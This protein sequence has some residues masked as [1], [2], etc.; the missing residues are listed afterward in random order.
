VVALINS[1]R[2]ILVEL[3]ERNA[4]KHDLAIVKQ[5]T[6]L[7]KKLLREYFIANGKNFKHLVDSLRNHGCKKHEVTIR[8]W[9]QDENRIGPDDDADLISIALMTDSKLLYDNIGKVREA[10]RK[11]TGW[12]MKASDFISDKIKT[13]IHEFAGGLI[14]SKKLAIEGLGSVIVLKVT[15]ISNIWE[16]IDVRYVNRLLQRENI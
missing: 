9:L 3:V 7:W 1:D 16:N 2:D 6:D 8:T 14:V 15:E 10:I 5:W 11:M 4:N 12:R 13:R